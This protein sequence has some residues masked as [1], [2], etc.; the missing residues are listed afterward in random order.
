M[1][2][3]PALVVRSVVILE[4]DRLYIEVLRQ[5]VRRVFPAAAVELVNLSE[6]APASLPA[7]ATKPAELFVVGIGPA[8]DGDILDLLW[9]RTGHRRGDGRMLVI[10]SRREYRLLSA[11]RALNV[12]G[13][14]DSTDE[15]PEQLAEALRHVAQGA[16]YWSPS[17]LVHLQRPGTAGTVFRLLTSFEQIVLSVIGDGCD[18]NAAADA[19]QVSPSTVSTVR[20]DL[21][22]KLGVQHRGELVRLAAQ[23]GF[24]RF[25]PGRI[26]RPG[27]A[28]LS[29][30]Y[31]ARRTRKCEGPAE[32]AHPA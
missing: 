2:S 3:A 16:R 28:M 20:R 8:A 13:V 1:N 6:A 12:D 21:H 26:V 7:L 22:R 17:I 19:L 30:S 29:A 27:F 4:T 24:V 11:L 31:Q 15:P 9:M 14:F 5:Y 23:Q 25:A 32:L 10:T 18:D